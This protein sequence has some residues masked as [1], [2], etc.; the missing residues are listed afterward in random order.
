MNKK[1][2]ALL[3]L[4]T[5]L[6]L[7]LFMQSCNENDPALGSATVV[8]AGKEIKEFEVSLD[9]LDTDRGLV[10][11]LDKLKENGEIDYRITDTYLDFVGEVKNDYAKS[12]FI[13][14][15]TSVEKDFDVSEMKST[16]EYEGKELTSSGVGALDMTIEDGAVYYITTIKW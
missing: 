4:L 7:S 12:E 3:L 13:F 16:I 11:L 2:V 15:Y 5:T 14:V 9:G 1:I 6:F 10:A 8:V